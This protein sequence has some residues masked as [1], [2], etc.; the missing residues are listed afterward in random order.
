ML[1]VNLSDAFTVINKTDS[2]T[3]RF[4]P[5]LVNY[6]DEFCFVI[7]G[8]GKLAASVPL[9]SVSC[10]NIFQ[11][12]W[13]PET[14]D[15]PLLNVARESPSGC[16]LGNFVFVFG[17][18]TEKQT[19]INSIEKLNVTTM[20][21]D[22]G[23]DWMLIKIPEDVFTPRFGASVAPINN[24]EIAIL[25]GRYS[26]GPLR[27][28]SLLSDVLIFDASKNSCCMVSNGGDFNFWS[29]DNQTYFFD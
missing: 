13:D 29:E 22:V 4:C 25:G 20:K 17:G 6:K 18:K 8:L 10:Y 28:D 26:I 1:T 2:D 24:N 9:G 14:I 16:S 12:K 11:D 5:T 3:K 15:I 7:G 27:K 19:P 21:N 23:Y